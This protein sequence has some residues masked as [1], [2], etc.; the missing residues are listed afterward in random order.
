MAGGRPE[1][2]QKSATLSVT[3]PV[4]LHRVLRSYARQSIL[5]TTENEVARYLLVQAVYGL[6]QGRLDQLDRIDALEARIE[7]EAREPSE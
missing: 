1:S 3:I 4:T 5:G 7:L 2:K 6:D